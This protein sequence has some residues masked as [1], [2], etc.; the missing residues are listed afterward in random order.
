MVKGRELKYRI[1]LQPLTNQTLRKLYL[2]D[3]LLFEQKQHLGYPVYLSP[4]AFLTGSDFQKIQLQFPKVL[5]QKLQKVGNH[6]EKQ[7]NRCSH[8]A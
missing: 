7:R 8:D 5:K 6:R 3:Q 4:H 1:K 2:P